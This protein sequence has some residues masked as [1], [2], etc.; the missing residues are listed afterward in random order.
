MFPQISSNACSYVCSTAT[1]I[2]IRERW[3]GLNLLW[4]KCCICPLLA[5]CRHANRSSFY[6]SLLK[7][8]V[9]RHQYLP[10]NK[11]RTRIQVAGQGRQKESRATVF[12]TP[13][14]W[15]SP[16]NKAN[17]GNSITE[18]HG[19][20]N[21]SCFLASLHFELFKYYLAFKFIKR[22]LKSKFIFKNCYLFQ[23]N[24]KVCFA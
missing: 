23:Q 18:L 3:R 1:G 2:F 24:W 14:L 8:P 7:R 15:P 11:K 10:E 9:H 19:L 4:L 16:I 12:L 5:L 20:C 21:S 17:E 22:T 6:T 13:Y